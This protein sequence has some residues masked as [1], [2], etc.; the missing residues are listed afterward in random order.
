MLHHENR[1]M[2]KV[3]GLTKSYG[4]GSAYNEVIKDVNFT[5]NSGEYFLIIGPSGSGKSTLLYLLA[6][7]ETPSRGSIYVRG[8]D[9]QFF[10]R[11]SLA[12][13]HRIHIGIV[14]QSFHLLPSFTILENVAFPLML[15]GLRTKKREERAMEVLERFGIDALAAHLPSQISGGQQ[16]KTAIARAIINMP[17]ILLIDEPTGNL[18]TQSSQ[19]VMDIIEILHK[20]G[21]QTIIM[22]THNTEFI[23]YSTRTVHI[24]DG[25]IYNKPSD[26]PS[27]TKADLDT[28]K[29]MEKIKQNQDEDID[30][31]MINPFDKI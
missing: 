25:K 15:Q 9:I 29:L 7:L 18:D 17:P 10:D 1:A 26:I 14:Y 8:Q 31:F 22:V 2:Y 13:F 6:G 12:T 16:Q 3:E 23:K 5:I 11:N 24:I 4:E 19:E 30:E 20:Q 28:I 27:K 21:G